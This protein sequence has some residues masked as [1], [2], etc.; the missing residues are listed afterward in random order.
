MNEAGF[1]G[2]GASLGADIALLAYILV[3]IPAMLLGFVF[4]RRKMF[5]PHHKFVMTGI[6]TVNWILIITIMAVSYSDSVA[7]NLADNSS[8]FSLIL[9]TIHL[10]TGGLA[11][12][13]ATYLALRMWFEKSLPD[14]IK[15]KNIKLYM[16]L[17]LALWLITALLGI[18]IYARWYL[19][20]SDDSGET[21]IPVTTEEPGATTP[22]TTEEPGN[23]PDPAATEES[24]SDDN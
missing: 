20:S 18:G 12:L 7:P 4:A 23:V 22:T 3:L 24:D 9:P 13:L 10:I 8:D 1:L 17:T 5:V 15:V 11:Q 2:T 16:R 6:V 19:G 14:W 21:P